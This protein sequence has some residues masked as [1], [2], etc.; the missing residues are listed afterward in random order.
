MVLDSRFKS[1]IYIYIPI[2]F[3]LLYF[4]VAHFYVQRYLVFIYSIK[5]SF[6]SYRLTVHLYSQ[7]KFDVGH[8]K[9]VLQT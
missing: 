3:L 1:K 4:L 2:V 6:T 9:H 7:L 5:L 8:P